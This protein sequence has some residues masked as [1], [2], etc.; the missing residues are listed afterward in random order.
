M[1][2]L[3]KTCTDCGELKPVTDFNKQGKYLTSRCK[4]CLALARKGQYGR[5][6]QA[7]KDRWKRTA[8]ARRKWFGLSRHKSPCRVKVL[9]I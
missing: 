6:A 5:T 8:T 3:E 4:P 1:A 7:T 2:S 9:Y